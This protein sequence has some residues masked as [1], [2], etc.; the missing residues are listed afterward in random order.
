MQLFVDRGGTWYDRISQAQRASHLQFKAGEIMRAIYA[1]LIAMWVA[2]SASNLNASPIAFDTA[3]DSAYNNFNPNS[4]TYPNG[5]YGWGGPWQS[6]GS[7]FV[8]QPG[9]TG[10]GHPADTAPINSPMTSAGRAWGISYSFN[11]QF[12]AVERPL[13]GAL[14]PGQAF[15]V[16]LDMRTT[17][18]PQY[19]EGDDQS[20]VLGSE[21]IA[22]GVSLN[23]YGGGVYGVGVQ[24]F[25]AAP[26]Y[27]V[28]ATEVPV[29][30]QY[31]HLDVTVIDDSSVRVTLPDDVPIT[32]LKLTNG[33]V[34]YL[35]D[36]E[37]YFNNIQITPEPVGVIFPAG[38]LAATL[39]G[40]RRRVGNF[41][42]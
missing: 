12:S 14:L 2:V 26:T 42:S 9:L 31:I 38:A 17:S 1:A 29:S 33:G 41:M 28:F 21:E 15:S 11:E 34:G 37:L 4:S 20:V 25:G 27:T 22:S 3:G 36:D 19:G 5:G 18:I 39:L 16:D 35:P 32:H 40:R 7:L 23:S 6:D 10:P 24:V 8:N 30:D 13:A